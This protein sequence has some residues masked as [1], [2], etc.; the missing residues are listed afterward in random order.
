MPLKQEIA[1]QLV[2]GFS[3]KLYNNSDTFTIYKLKAGGFICSYYDF[4]QHCSVNTNS[5]SKCRLPKDKR[6]YDSIKP[7]PPLDKPGNF[8]TFDGLSYHINY[9]ERYASG[10]TS[11]FILACLSCK[12]NGC[13]TCR[14]TGILYDK[15]SPDWYAVT[16][17]EVYRR[18]HT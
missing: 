8:C 3:F 13:I 18:L 6:N 14:F 9:H 17:R 15:S 11:S 5:I 1:D 7:A 16:G 2:D 4:Q 10:V 12:G